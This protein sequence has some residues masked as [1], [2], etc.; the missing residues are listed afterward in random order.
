MGKLKR[1]EHGELPKKFVKEVYTRKVL[2]GKELKGFIQFV[3]ELCFM[4]RLVDYYDTVLSDSV[5]AT[6]EMRDYVL[7]VEELLKKISEMNHDNDQ[8]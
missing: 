4:R 5:D 8:P 3:R 7:K 1:W 6:R 2:P